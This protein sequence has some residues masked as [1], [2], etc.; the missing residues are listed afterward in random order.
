VLDLHA[1][2]VDPHAHEEIDDLLLGPDAS[3]LLVITTGGST[4]SNAVSAAMA[5]PVYVSRLKN[6]ID[7]R[8]STS[9][10]RFRFPCAVIGARS[11]RRCFDL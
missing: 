11:A 10:M 9:G 3:R 5:A 6:T 4:R 8:M 7:V 1:V 2:G